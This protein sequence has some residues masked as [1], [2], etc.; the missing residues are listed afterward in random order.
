VTPFIAVLI[1]G[2]LLM[3]IHIDMTLFGPMVFVPALP[4]V[5]AALFVTQLAQRPQERRK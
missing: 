1:G 5:L 4:I 3:L 2:F